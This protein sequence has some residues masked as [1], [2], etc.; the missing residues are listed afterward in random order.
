MGRGRAARR[1][2]GHPRLS[3]RK[4]QARKWSGCRTGD[5]MGDVS[6]YP[7]GMATADRALRSRLDAG[8]SFSFEFFSAAGRRRGGGAL[9]GRP[10]AGAARGPSFVSV[11]YGAGGSTR[12]RS[13][14][15]HRRGSPPTRPHSGRP[16]D[17]RRGVPGPSS[18]ASS[19]VCRTPACAPSSPSGGTR[20]PAPGA[21]GRRIPRGSTT[22]STSS[23]WCASSGRSRV[24]VAA[25][26]DVHPE[27]PDV[28]HD[29]PGPGEQGRGR[30]H[31]RDHPVHLRQGGASAW[32]TGLAALGC[33]LPVIPGI[34][35]V[36]N[37]RQ[38]A[39]FP[40]AVGQAAAA[41][42]ARPAGGRGRRPGRAPLCRRRIATELSRHAAGGGR[43]RPALL[44]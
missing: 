38:I 26:P 39:R 22:P 1:G 19:A 9:G 7:F 15:H 33:D 5:W 36:T 34:M 13:D 41:E 18:G 6:P 43:P 28:D 3:S 42:G 30:G 21:R 25:F 4:R 40:A 35:P 11:T 24:G 44:R 20:P 29:A 10:P 16:S 14:A 17:L 8:R 32:W 12:D 37:M 27:S 23:G 31:V 2:P